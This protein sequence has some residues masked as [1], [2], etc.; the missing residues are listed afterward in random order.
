MDSYF[1]IHAE[2]QL[3]NIVAY[4]VPFFEIGFATSETMFGIISSIFRKCYKFT[5]ISF[6]DGNFLL[7]NKDMISSAQFNEIAWS[8]LHLCLLRIGPERVSL[9]SGPFEV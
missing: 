6:V 1:Y 2:K 8:V 3:P 9:L 4:G 7:I 5:C